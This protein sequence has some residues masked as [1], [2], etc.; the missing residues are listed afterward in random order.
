MPGT[1]ISYL[2]L[3]FHLEMRLGKNCSNCL[4]FFKRVTNN[5]KNRQPTLSHYIFTTYFKMATGIWSG[6]GNGG[7]N[8]HCQE[9]DDDQ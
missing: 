4:L 2:D 3:G 1:H 7:G 6:A 8:Q 9:A 5:K